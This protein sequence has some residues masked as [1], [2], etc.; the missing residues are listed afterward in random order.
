MPTDSET[1][2]SLKQYDAL[3]LGESP[4]PTYNSDEGERYPLDWNSL[5][6]R[7]R[8]R[9]RIEGIWDIQDDSWEPAW[10]QEFLSILEDDLRR[11]EPIDSELEQMGKAL[12]WDV[13]AWYQPIHFFAEQ[14]GIYIRQDC[15][16]RQ[17]S[18]VSRK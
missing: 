7:L 10:D 5:F 6:P 17:A 12:L 4:W 15:I 9:R 2:D 11:E 16:L 1:I 18:V 8:E 13:C 3:K 14:W